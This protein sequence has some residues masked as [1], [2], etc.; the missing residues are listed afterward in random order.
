MPASAD[1][2]TSMRTN[3]FRL[4]AA[5]TLAVITTGTPVKAQIL[6]SE[7]GSVS[8]TVDGTVISIEYSRPSLRGRADIFNT[9]VPR[10]QLW[11]PGADDATTIAFSK[12]VTIEG[13]P[14]PA[15]KY[16]LWMVS[17][18]AGWQVVLD[19]DT[20]LFHLPHPKPSMDQ[21]ALSVPAD[22]LAPFMETLTLSFPAVRATGADLR[23]H[24]ERT[25]VDM[26]I[27]VEPTR[28]LT[29]SAE[30]AA[31]YLGHWK[32][33]SLEVPFAEANSFDFDLKYA[34]PHLAGTFHMFAE[35]DP[36]DMF[37]APSADQI[38]NPVRVINDQI[39]GVFDWVYFEFEMGEDGRAESF[40]AR[41][42]DDTLWMKGT[43]V[44]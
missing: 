4:A 3:Y 20:T 35:V 11:T 25:A 24:W 10:N 9:E 14:V 27:V 8:Q 1:S 21:I 18:R 2:I 6:A 15:G 42:Q 17:S 34:E 32:V 29:V 16:S 26:E 39:T 30:D 7:R 33:E 36:F 37:F 43:R 31:P 28:D 13:T 40:Q 38:F 19:P 23:M 41:L 5:A 22:T 12:D 44:D